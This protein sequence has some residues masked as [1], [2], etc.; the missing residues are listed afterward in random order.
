LSEAP[1]Q[2]LRVLDLSRVLAG[3]YCTMLLADLGADVVKVERP[4]T[5]DETRTWGPP[6]VGGESAYF[7]SLNRTKRSVAL[8]LSDDRARA[9]FSKL[10]ETADVVVE[11]FRPGGA[12][13]LGVGY[14]QV[15]ALSPRVV[16]C[17]ITGFGAREPADRAAYDFVVQ[18]EAGLMSVTGEPDGEPAKAGVAVADV[19]AGV[20][21]AVAVLA[22][23]HRRD[24]T[25]QGSQVTVSLLDSTLSGLVNVA[26]NVLVTGEEA[27]RYGNA[28]GSIAPYEPLR[29]QNGWVAVAAANDAQ[30]EKLCNALGRYDLLGDPRFATNT[31]RVEHRAELALQLD[32]T[33][34]GAT[35]EEWIER[36]NDAGVP[37]GKIRG[38]KEALEAA[39]AAGEA[40][41][42]TVEHPAI[43]P[44]DLVRSAPRFDG[45]E[46]AP[47]PPP[48][49]GEH[50]REVLLEAGVDEAE[51]EAIVAANR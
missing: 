12:N 5:G 29:A 8:D 1:L 46:A 26:Q 25:G 22:A 33:F 44:L 43:G 37:S 32:E 9:A 2:G 23:L 7:L 28:H 21:A 40:A 45:A 38:V 13:A 14:E 15:R 36:L 41:T 10:A 42:V 30:F 19:L 50:T 27:A 39:A 51:I 4:G 3:P 34:A 6:F 35:A 47:T 17:S 11:N 18:A 20:N 16:Y 49:L 31:S 48:L 24:R